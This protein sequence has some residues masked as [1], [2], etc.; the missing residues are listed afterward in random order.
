MKRDPQNLLLARGPR[1]RL[2]AEM[3]RDLAYTAGGIIDLQSPGPDPAFIPT[4]PAGTWD[5]PYNGEQ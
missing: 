5:T 2:E 4:N 1:F 3:I